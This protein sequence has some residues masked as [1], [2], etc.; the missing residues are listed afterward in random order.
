MNIINILKIWRNVS[1][2]N[3]SGQNTRSSNCVWVCH[4]LFAFHVWY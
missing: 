2:G 1:M 4:W 3:I